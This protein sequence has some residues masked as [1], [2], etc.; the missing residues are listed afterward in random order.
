MKAFLLDRYGTPD[1]LRQA[2]IDKPS[3][4]Q[5]EVLIR[6]S[7]VSLNLADWEILTGTPLYSRIWGLRRPRFSILGSDVAGVVEEVGTDVDRLKP[8]DAVYGDL[9]GHFGCFAEYVCAPARQLLS[10]PA[11]LSFTDAATLPQAG[12]IAWQG[13][14]GQGGLRSGEKVLIIGAGGGGGTLAVQIARSIGAEVTAVDHGDKAAFLRELGAD[15]FIDYTRGDY[16][17]QGHRYHLILDLVATLPLQRHRRM[18]LP[19]GR[20]RLVGGR[21]S[22][23]LQALLLGPLYSIAGDVSMGLLSA[24]PVPEDLAQVTELVQAGTIRPVIDRCWSLDELPEAF[25]S[26]RTPTDQCKV[27]VTP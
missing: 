25:E 10:K 22:C 3:P 11:G 7:A 6:I 1:D 24:R 5:G 16:T 8:G 14:R 4:G 15:H 27:V 21:M 12:V 17:D 26:L 19:G 23:V 9:M 20:Y 18:L 13:I 2:T